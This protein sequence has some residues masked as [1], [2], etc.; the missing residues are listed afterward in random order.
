MILFCSSCL[1]THELFSTGGRVVGKSAC[2]DFC[3]GAMGFSSVDGYICNPELPEYR[4]GGSSGGS[5]V[6]VSYCSALAACFFIK[7]CPLN[8]FYIK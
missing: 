7:S 4:I 8:K 6:L 5:A 1:R 3:L 2:D